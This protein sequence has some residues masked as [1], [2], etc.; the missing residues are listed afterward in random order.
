ML[1]I[2]WRIGWPSGIGWEVF[3][4][5]LDRRG[6]KICCSWCGEEDDAAAAVADDRGLAD[7]VDEDGRRNDLQ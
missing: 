2:G 1:P 5:S 4:D 3:L 6:D 7:N